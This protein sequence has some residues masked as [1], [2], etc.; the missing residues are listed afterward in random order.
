MKP[1]IGISMGDPAGIGPEIIAKALSREKVHRLCRPIVIGDASVMR[2]ATRYAS[3]R[4]TVRPQSRVGD[5]RFEADCIDVYDLHNVDLT[6]LELG[7]VSAMAGNA[8]FE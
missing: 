7:K 3:A 6:R 5:A 2:K 4:L 8:A 1:I